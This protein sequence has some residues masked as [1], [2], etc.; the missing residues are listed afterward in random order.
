MRYIADLFEKTTVDEALFPPRCCNEIALA[1]V[2]HVLSPEL[3]STFSE[4]SVEFCTLHRVYCATATC[5]KF[6]GAQTSQ[7]AA[8]RCQACSTTTCSACK[9]SHPIEPGMTCEQ[10]LDELKLTEL[11]KAHGWKRCPACSRMV[12]RS[13]G[14]NWMPCLCGKAFCYQCG[15]ICLTYNDQCR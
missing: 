10:G 11:A 6:L 7:P 5:S 3:R 12:E 4:K 15:M 13:A 9:G 14:C 1:D 8:L 2:K